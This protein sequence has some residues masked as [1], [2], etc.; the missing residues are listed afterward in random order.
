MWRISH[1]LGSYDEQRLSGFI[2]QPAFCQRRFDNERVAVLVALYIG[3]RYHNSV[4]GCADP[5]QLA[6]NLPHKFA[7]VPTLE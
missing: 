3:G 4:H 1:S 5:V 2:H 6:V 7:R